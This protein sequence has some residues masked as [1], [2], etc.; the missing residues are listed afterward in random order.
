[1]PFPITDLNALLVYSVAMSV[2]PGPNNA[3]LASLGAR[4]GLRATAPAAA[5][6]MAG[7]GALIVAA[8]LGVAAMLAAMPGV[9]LGMTLAGVLYM[10]YL[11][12]HLWR[13]QTKAAAG[14]RPPLGFWG[15][16]AFQAINPKALLMATTIAGTFL[17]P[18]AGPSG[19]ATL[20]AIF[21]I[22]GLPCI[23]LWALAGDRLQNWLAEPG[24]AR[25]FSRVMATL[26]ALTALAILAGPETRSALG[27][28]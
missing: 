2:T 18:G 28:L 24:R 11:A 19:A 7:M 3:M 22:V 15:A 27:T 9:R 23:A 20:A 6:V 17:A 10:G 12:L 26:L 21:V 4:Y 13:A 25:A 8:G 5:G 1:M 14:E 16:V